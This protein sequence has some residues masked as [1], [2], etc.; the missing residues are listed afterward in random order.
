MS[1]TI[2]PQNHS[3][4]E[5]NMSVSNFSNLWVLLGLEPTSDEG[6]VGSISANDL[7]HVLYQYQVDTDSTSFFSEKVEALLNLTELFPNETFI[8]C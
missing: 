7:W 5:I 8:W 2:F 4:N 6:T 3:D 1:I